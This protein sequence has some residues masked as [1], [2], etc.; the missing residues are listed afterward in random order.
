MANEISTQTIAADLVPL[1]IRDRLLERGDEQLLFAKMGMPIELPEG[2][3]KVIQA[4]RYE[5]IALPT[6]P[7]TEGSTPGNTA[8]SPSIVQGVVDQ[9]GGV[10][11]LYDV[12]QMTAKHPLLRI[13]QDLLGDQRAE[14]VDREVQRV[15]LGTSNVNFANNKSSRASLLTTDV[16][17]STDIRRIIA[18]LRQNGARAQSGGKFVGII[19]P[20]VEQDLNA[21]ATFIAAAYNQS[22]T[23]LGGGG[24]VTA[25]VADWMG[26]SWYRSNFLPTISLLT[27]VAAA[28]AA[29]AGGETGFTAA[30]TVRAKVTK[31]DARTGFET[32]V[33]AELTATDAAAF[34]LTIAFT[35]A[36]T[37]TGTFNIYVTGAGGATGT[38]TFQRQ[39]TVTADVTYR[40]IMA[41]TPSTNLTSVVTMTGYVAPPSPAASVTVHTSYIFGEGWYG[42][43]RLGGLS[44]HLTPSTASDSDPLVQRRK[45]GWKQMFK[46]IV[47]NTAFGRRIESAS[48]Y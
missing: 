14:T 47:L 45:V 48:A 18:T 27:G 17:S 42:V 31:L 7:L 8:L 10:M 22:Q 32:A 39:V 40:F 44:T 36:T 2:N 21:D 33:S 4:T 34:V 16:M 28:D 5:R 1:Y 43:T 35:A 26:V 11:T 19:D 30:S 13:S 38:A 9:W 23:S 37:G 20:S 3:G 29:E 12:A 25:K 41:G 15:L 24:L 6:S 46:A